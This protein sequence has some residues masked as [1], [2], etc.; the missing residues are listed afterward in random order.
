V[1]DPAASE[2]ALEP[3]AGGAALGARL[4]QEA[5]ESLEALRAVFGVPKLRR[6]QLAWACSMVSG[7]AFNVAL[8]VF[9]FD[10]GGAGAVGLAGLVRMLPS[11]LLAPFAGVLG[12]RLPRQRVMVGADLVAVGALAGA[13]L[14]AEARAP[15]VV[16]AM[17]GVVGVALGI[18]RPAQ[19]A[20]LP[21]LTSTPQQLTAANVVSSTI[22]SVGFF[23]GPA[24]G[25]LLLAA[26]GPSVVFA[27]TGAGFLL[28][29]AFVARID[30]RGER[31]APEPAEAGLP[32]ALVRGFVTIG[33][34][35]RL[36]LLVGLFS[37]QTVVAGA[38][39]VLIVVSALDLLDMG[40]SGVGVLNSAVG[41]GGVVGALGAF[42]L[43]GRRTLAPPFGLGILLWGVPI[44]LLGLLPGKGSALVLMAVIG[45]GNTLVDVSGF[46]LLQR[47]VPDEVLARVFAVLE[48]LLVGTIALGSILAPVVVDWLGVRGALVAFGG[49]LPVVVALMWRPLLT[50][51]AA[52]PP[53]AREIDLL[54]GHAIFRPLGPLALE[55]LAAR[56]VPLRF[57]PGTPVFRQGDAGDRF[58]LIADGEVDVRIDGRPVRVEGPGEGFG[59]IA[60]LGEVPRT[61]TVTARGAARALRARARGLPRGGERGGGER[62]RRRLGGGRAP[63]ERAPRHDLALGAAAPPCLR[64]TIAVVFHD[65][66]KIWVQGGAGGDG[67]VSFRREAHV[68]KGGPDG[69]DGGRGGDVVLVCDSSLRDLGSFRRGM[70]FRARRG[71]HGEGAN[72]HGATPP[73]LEVRVPPGTMA[74]DRAR[75]VRWELVEPGARAVAAH[76]G[77][78]GRGNKHFATPTRQAPRFAERG[79][80]GEEGWIELRLRLLADAGLVGLPN[81]GKS[82]LLDRLTRAHP[83][84]ADYPFT[85]VEPVLGTLESDERQL[86]LADIPGLIEG[87]SEG[88]GLGH[89]FLAHVERCRLLVH[90]LD[91]APM[92]GSAPEE[93]HAA[94]EEELRRHGAGLAGLPRLLC[95]SKADLVPEQEARRAAA[96]WERRMGALEVVVTSAVTGLGLD[97][98]RGAIFRHVPAEEAPAPQRAVARHR[99][100]RPGAGDALRVER[101]GPGAFRVEGGRVERLLARHDVENEEAMRYVEDRLRALGVIRALEAAGFEPGDDV[102]IGGVVFELDPGAPFR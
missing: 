71:G 91:L 75:G 20:L 44:A 39:N 23:A 93:N 48:G 67:S 81:A 25:G 13:A 69:G 87:A 36:R 63:L 21:S 56:L 79:L 85:T 5:S 24:L 49:V 12:D 9:A 80:P 42:M 53:S 90:V 54:R 64:P 31:R 102:E 7:W 19:S 8:F 84:V 11:A 3:P 99:V 73:P 51:D 17:G 14:A 83:K 94:V 52:A 34:E 77:S 35:R 100:Y 30:A 101:A 22:E 76:G 66:A 32:R 62:A 86:V 65:R 15:G 43:V 82:S 68:P 29:T 16:Y 26:T 45:L 96:G 60:L 58:Y 89:E 28:S 88:A 70:H 72:R 10:V 4:R 6:I 97:E 57:E 40:D 50:I 37:A 78:G 98:L 2:L 47:A 59:E 61:A 46:T 74:E 18:F 55:A 27:I 1:P 38:L 95:L 92:D 41:V 33:S